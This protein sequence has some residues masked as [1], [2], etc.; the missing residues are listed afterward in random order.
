M[1]TKQAM[2][3]AAGKGTR[4]KPLTDSKPKALVEIA[5]KP[6]IQIIIERLKEEG[7]THITVNVCHFAQMIED[8]LKANN[9]FNIHINI[10]DESRE[11]L[12]TGGAIKHAAKYFD[13]T[14]PLLIHNTD[15]ISNANLAMLYE[16]I[17]EEDA[18]LLVNNRK[19]NRLLLFENRK[20]AGWI[21]TETQKSK[22]ATQNKDISKLTPLAFS[23]IHVIQ[24]ALIKEMNN[25]QDKFGIIDFYLQHFQ[26]HQIKAFVQENLLMVDAGKPQSLA[27]AEQ[28]LN[29]IKCNK[30]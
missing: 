6:M 12:D 26:T 29:K 2:I 1:Q 18:L 13:H 3:L 17:K 27:E 22:T 5:G 8:F 15:I 4:L 20:L 14:A 19:T 9:N 7:F 25:M 11:P 21:N 24:P 23:G 10:S 30:K 28:L 16:N